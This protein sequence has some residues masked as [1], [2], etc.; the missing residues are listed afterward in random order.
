MHRGP[1]TVVG[2]ISLLVVAL[3]VVDA[4]LVPTRFRGL[5]T[6]V[7]GAIKLLPL[8]FLPTTWSPGSWR[9]A[10]NTAGGFVGATAV[11]AMILPQDSLLYWTKLL[12]QTARVGDMSSLR[13]KSLLGLPQSPRSGSRRV[14]WLVL[15][16]VFG[17]IGLWQAWRCHQRGEEFAGCCAG[18]LVVR[19]HRPDHLAAPPG[20]VVVGDG[21]CGADRGPVVAGGR[22]RNGDRFLRV[23]SGGDLCEFGSCDDAGDPISDRA[24]ADGLCG[25]RAP[26]DGVDRQTRDS[27]SERTW[28]TPAMIAYWRRWEPADLASH[29]SDGRGEPSDL[30]VFYGA[31]RQLMDGGDLYAFAILDNGVPT[32]F[33]YPPFAALVFMPIAALPYPA[34]AAVWDLLQ[35]VL[36]VL[37][38]WLISR[39][40][41]ASGVADQAAGDADAELAVDGGEHSGA[42]CA[43]TRTARAD[44]GRAGAD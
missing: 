4:L 28:P 25:V 1:V 8:L 6:G 21:L 27:M 29:S 23:L 7:A 2:Q 40:S 15:A 17:V 3:V 44:F 36:V 18:G 38:L 30:R 11:A 26:V 12:F 33:L 19:A 35:V 14:W 24:D 20:L 13:N 39:G 16:A 5:L 37:L 32:P 34:A 9:A 42:R 41:E 43:P 31:V 22:S 10:A